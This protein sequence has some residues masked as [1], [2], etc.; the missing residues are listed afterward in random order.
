MFVLIPVYQDNIGLISLITNKCFTNIN[1]TSLTNGILA[2]MVAITGF[3]H[4]K[5]C[6][7]NNWADCW[8]YM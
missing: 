7:F 3:L 4:S 5:L 6:S 2:G 1:A 8:V